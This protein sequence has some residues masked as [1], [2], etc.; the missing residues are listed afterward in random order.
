MLTA[1]NSGAPGGQAGTVKCSKMT[2]KDTLPNAH[3]IKESANSHC[4]GQTKWAS[5][6]TNRTGLSAR[7]PVCQSAPR[8]RERAL[9]RTDPSHPSNLAQS[10]RPAGKEALCGQVLWSGRRARCCPPGRLPTSCGGTS[11]PPARL[12]KPKSKISCTG[13]RVQRRPSRWTRRGLYPD[14]L[15]PAGRGGQG[16]VPC[17]FTAEGDLG[18][19]SSQAKTLKTGQTD[20]NAS[21]RAA[22]RG[23]L[24]RWGPEPGGGL[25]APPQPAAVLLLPQ[26]PRQNSAPAR[27][28]A[29][30]QS[31]C[32]ARSSWPRGRRGLPWWPKAGTPRPQRRRP[33]FHLWSGN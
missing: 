33:R 30:A 32:T 4:A 15:S 27:K 3:S 14:R 1:P 6:R 8:H 9:E 10:W 7:A 31:R 12:Q 21:P 17:C 13:A 18:K 16:E 11:A 2:E 20:P 23:V 29:S 25:Q 5:R 26:S 24:G 22:G 28:Q 19:I